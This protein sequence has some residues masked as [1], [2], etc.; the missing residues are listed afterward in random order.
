MDDEAYNE[1][2]DEVG[3]ELYDEAYY[4][5]GLLDNDKVGNK[6]NNEV[7]RMRSW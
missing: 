5:N 7:K 3:D 4:S 2:D 6:Y 1:Y